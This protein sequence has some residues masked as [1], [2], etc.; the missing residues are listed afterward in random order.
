MQT[1]LSAPVQTSK[2]A[3]IIKVLVGPTCRP[4]PYLLPKRQ[5]CFNSPYLRTLIEKAEP[6]RT[7]CLPHDDPA[8]MELL[9]TWMN[10][11]Q[12]KPCHQRGAE[13]E[14]KIK[15]KDKEGVPIAIK[16]W[17]L[18]HRL[19]GPCL[20]LRDECMRYLYET[21]AMPPSG[22]TGLVI[23]PAIGMYAFQNASTRI[24]LRH[25]VFACLARDGLQGSGSVCTWDAVLKQVQGLRAALQKAWDGSKTERVEKLLQLEDYM[26]APGEI[27]PGWY[28]KQVASRGLLE[29]A[30]VAWMK[31][32]WGEELD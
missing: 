24:E 28:Q 21:C 30:G 2:A 22:K 26:C 17:V 8:A 31:M 10:Y 14:K 16:V 7:I 18:A 23:T 12:A 20:V 25:L 13:L 11:E 32:D 5:L 29:I 19:G 4:Q 6:S 3:E 15:T 1:Q 9:I 27:T